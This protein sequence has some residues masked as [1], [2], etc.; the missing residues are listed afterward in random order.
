MAA[1]SC[2]YCGATL[3][4]PLK[5]CL[6]CGRPVSSQEAKKLG[7]LK[8]TMKAGV[9]KRLDETPSPSNFDLARKS[10]RVQRTLREFATT[11]FYILLLVSLYYFAVKFILKQ[12]LPG[13]ADVVIRNW[14][15]GQQEAPRPG[16]A[17]QEPAGAAAREPEES[18]VSPPDELP[19]KSKV[20]PKAATKN[21]AGP[22]GRPAKQ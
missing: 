9:T 16:P 2:P 21:K 14:L 4:L 10:Y 5:F 13:N 12:A 1:V 11:L 8:S 22:S 19:Q 17:A 6:S 15:N 3:N 18:S 7:G 20:R